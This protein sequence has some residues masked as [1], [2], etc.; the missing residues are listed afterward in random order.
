[1]TR[2]QVIHIASR[3]RIPL[4]AIFVLL[5]LNFVAYGL[6][7]FYFRPD[8]D[9]AR[10]EWFMKR[11][12]AAGEREL[13]RSEQ[14]VQGRKDLEDWN[15]RILAKKDFAPF[16]SRLFAMASRHNLELAGITYKPTLESGRPLAAYVIGFSVRGSY[17]GVKEFLSDVSLL[18]EMVVVDTV[19]LTSTK[20]TED[21]VELRM[22]LTSYFK[23]DRP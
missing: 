4:I 9:R 10:E 14:Y 7:S 3:R 8:L 2:K 5:V 18:R 19:S 1:M 16:L 11:R 6:L 23:V 22:Q 15:S 20:A 12:T 21:Q 17:S 13:S